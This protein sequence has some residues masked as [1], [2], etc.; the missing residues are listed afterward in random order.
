M[1]KYDRA[2]QKRLNFNSIID[3][4]ISDENGETDATARASSRRS[5]SNRGR[6]DGKRWGVAGRACQANWSTE[7][8]HQHDYDEEESSAS[9][10]SAQDDRRL[11][12]GSGHQDQ[13]AKIT[14]EA[15]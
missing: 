12:V 6:D 14:G 9:R 15:A 8:E 4:T 7:T 3:Y 10:L 1:K 13:A 11:G 2:K 5:F